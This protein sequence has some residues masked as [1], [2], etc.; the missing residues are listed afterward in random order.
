MHV[1]L[2]FDQ[3]TVRFKTALFGFK[4]MF[5]AIL[6]YFIATLDTFVLTNVY[7]GGKERNIEQRCRLNPFLPDCK[8]S[9]SQF[10]TFFYVIF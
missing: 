7:F 1:F 8:T 9:F 10:F 4:P 6:P 3:F 5:Y 2:S